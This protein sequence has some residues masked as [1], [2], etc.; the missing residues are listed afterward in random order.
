MIVTGGPSPTKIKGGKWTVARFFMVSMAYTSAWLAVCSQLDFF[1]SLYGPQ[2]LL[3]LNIAY[4]LP[5]VPLLIVSSFLDRHLDAKL[6]D[7][8]HK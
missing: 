7:H 1:R 8:G 5:T 2:V 3:Q 6:G 4:Y